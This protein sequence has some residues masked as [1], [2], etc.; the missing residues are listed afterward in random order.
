ML[1]FIVH[2]GVSEGKVRYLF[3][4]EKLKVVPLFQ[5]YDIH[6]QVPTTPQLAYLLYLSSYLQI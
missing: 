5:Q 2:A 4:S 6:P 1:G 3:S